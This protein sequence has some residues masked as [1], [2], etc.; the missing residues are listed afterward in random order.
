MS[1]N[2]L[3]PDDL[4]ESSY[5]WEYLDHKNLE[6]LIKDAKEN[7]EIANEIKGKVLGTDLVFRNEYQKELAEEA[8]T[9]TFDEVDF[10]GFISMRI[11]YI[12]EVLEEYEFMKNLNDVVELTVKY[13][14]ELEYLV[15]HLNLKYNLGY[16]SKPELGNH[17]IPNDKFN[18]MF[19]FYFNKAKNCYVL[20]YNPFR[21]LLM[22]R[23]QN[24]NINDFL[25]SGN[26]QTEYEE[27]KKIKASTLKLEEPKE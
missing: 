2:Y 5:F 25:P 11:I 22:M 19:N 16:D 15:W 6:E 24:K 23:K 10:I 1:R 8:V 27:L 17:I 18:A 21:K 3:T 7:P 26:W 13:I 9:E 12:K 14:Y 20:G 4:N